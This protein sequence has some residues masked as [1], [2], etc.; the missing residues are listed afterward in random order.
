MTALE[1]ASAAG[2][3]AGGTKASSE[4]SPREISTKVV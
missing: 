2:S 4:E 1:A 3:D